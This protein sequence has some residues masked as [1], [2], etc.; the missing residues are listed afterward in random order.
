MFPTTITFITH[1][2]FEILMTMT[3]CICG[4][5]YYPSSIHLIF[6]C[7]FLQIINFCFSNI[8][9][10]S[11]EAIANRHPMA[12]MPFGLGPRNCIGLRFA[13]LEAKMALAE[14][15]RKYSFKPCCETNKKLLL[16]ESGVVIV[17]KNGVQVIL[18]PRQHK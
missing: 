11:K 2:L 3:P 14:I 18:V 5:V 1:F 15:L 17:P 7:L 10:F 9:R 6:I 8:Y 12:W 16:Q 4:N 13:L